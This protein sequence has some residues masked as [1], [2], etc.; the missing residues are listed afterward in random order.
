M[1]P[2]ATLARIATAVALVASPALSVPQD[3]GSS[4]Y[5]LSFPKG[6]PGAIIGAATVD[7]AG[8]IVGAAAS[9]VSAVGSA[10][11]REIEVSGEPADAFV[12]S[13]FPRMPIEPS[14]EPLEEGVPAGSL[15][16]S[17]VLDYALAP[18]SDG[19]GAAV[20]IEL[21]IDGETLFES[22]GKTEGAFA[23]TSRSIRWGA[24][25]SRA[26]SSSAPS[27]PRAAPPP[28]SRSPASSPRRHPQGCSRSSRRSAHWRRCVADSRGQWLRGEVASSVP[29]PHPSRCAEAPPDAQRAL[30]TGSP[31]A[32]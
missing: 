12:L 32:S 31:E 27:R 2:S 24:A 25:R 9:A 29:P 23:S 26:C 18:H 7:D 17:G 20:G 21:L 8:G 19:T 30:R 14:G 6:S 5:T 3:R 22:G 28:R 13:A 1:K 11:T 15:A 4:L 16:V 10:W